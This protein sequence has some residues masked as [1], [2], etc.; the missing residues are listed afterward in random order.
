MTKDVTNVLVILLSNS[1]Q[2]NLGASDDATYLL[3]VLLS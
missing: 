2:R 3:V 1:K